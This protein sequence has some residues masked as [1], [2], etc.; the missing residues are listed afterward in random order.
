MESSVYNFFYNDYLV[1]IFGSLIFTSMTL[2]LIWWLRPKIKIAPSI[3]SQK[4]K[5][6][7]HTTELKHPLENVYFIKIMNHSNFFKV[8]DLRFEMTL[9]I[10][11]SSPK[12][13]NYSIQRIRLKSDQ[14]WSLNRKPFFT[15]KAK[16]NYALQVTIDHEKD[17]LRLLKEHNGSYLEFKVV[18]KNNFSGITSI[19]VEPYRHK[20]SVVKGEYYYGNSFRIMRC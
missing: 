3:A 10:P 1:E 8:L 12:G 2:L 19:V 16:A 9:L 17:I 13:T 6:Y 20:S 5:D 15:K 7:N 11:E 14:M 18:A 4:Q